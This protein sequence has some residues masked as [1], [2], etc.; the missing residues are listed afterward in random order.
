MNVTVIRYNFS[1]HLYMY[2][3]LIRLS[4]SVDLSSHKESD[5]RTNDWQAAANM[6][7]QRNKQRNSL[8]LIM[9]DSFVI[10]RPVF[11]RLFVKV[12]EL[13]TYYVVSS[14]YNENIVV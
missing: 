9:T 11:L 13:I 14:R 4:V 1:K 10:D 3:R 5:L 8:G 7:E 2:T 6:L 12:K